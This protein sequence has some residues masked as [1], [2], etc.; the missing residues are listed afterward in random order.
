[1]PLENAKRRPGGGGAHE[2]DSPRPEVDDTEFNP[3]RHPGQVPTDRKVAARFV[4]SLALS[5]LA[6]IGGSP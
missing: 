3:L 4:L 6:G 1:M 5:E 2:K